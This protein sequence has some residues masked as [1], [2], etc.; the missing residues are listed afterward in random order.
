MSKVRKNTC[1]LALMACAL[2]VAGYASADGSWLKGGSDQKLKTLAAIQ[3]GLGTVMIEYGNRYSMMYFAAKGGNWD[4]AEYQLKEA[5]EIQEVG[6][7]T[8]PKR[9]EALKHFEQKYLD[10]IGKAIAAKNFEQFDAAFNDGI[11][12]CNACHKKEGFKFIKYALPAT[13]PSPILN[14]P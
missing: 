13:S 11:D 1:R 5:R 9:A 10:P 3:P 2:M 8:R 7:T 14:N 12:G 6:E 4:F